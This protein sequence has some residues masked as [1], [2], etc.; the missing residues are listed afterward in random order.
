[1]I[2]NKTI[3][4]LHQNFPGQFLHLCRALADTNR[5]FFIT[6]ATRNRLQNVKLVEYAPHR[7]P[8]PDIHL[9]LRTLEDAVL[10]GQGVARLLLQMQKENIRPDIIIGHSGWGETQ[11][12]KDVFP[13]VPLLS[14]IEFYYSATGA[15]V[16]FDPEFPSNPE[17]KFQLRVRN[18]MIL[19]CLEAT[20]VGLSPTHWQHA[21]IPAIFQPKVEVIHDGVDTDAVKPAESPS[22]TLGEGLHFDGSVPLVTFVA[23]NL[24]PYRG[25]HIFMRAVNRILADNPAAHIVIVGGDGVSYGARLP[26]GDSYKARALKENPIDDES[27]VHFVGKLEYDVF[28]KLLQTSDAHVYLTYPFVLSWSM[29]EA[30]ASGCLLIGSRTPPVEEVVRHGENGLLVN[31][32]DPAEIAATV[33]DALKRPDDFRDIRRAAR[34][35]VID[36][37]DLTRVC[38]PRQLAL[39][40]RMI[41]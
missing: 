35:T 13:D 14:Y 8:N 30:M 41:G 29:L 22:V 33:T 9:Y 10:H 12:V 20:D 27:R 17:L 7:A 38:L 21:R 1:M 28:K 34:Q 3:L 32:F 2:Q 31:F 25:F 4:F 11:F 23:R 26:E 36:R 40:Q 18:Q 37:Y 16:G 39:I 6:K 15:D 5:L 24:E 19:S